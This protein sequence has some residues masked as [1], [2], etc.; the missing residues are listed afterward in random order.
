MVVVLNFM[1]SFS[2]R[3]IFD[4]YNDVSCEYFEVGMRVMI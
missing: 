2:I 4:T 1:Y 3:G